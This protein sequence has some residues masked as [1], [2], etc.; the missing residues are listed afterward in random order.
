MIGGA[1]PEGSAPGP[2]VISLGE[3]GR[4]AGAR[5]GVGGESIRVVFGR[6]CE[7][8]SGVCHLARQGGGTW[9][10]DA[11]GGVILGKRRQ[12]AK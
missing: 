5:V 2:D 6:D 11:R 8:G 12:C 4:G 10:E 1:E 3:Q 9:K 7:I